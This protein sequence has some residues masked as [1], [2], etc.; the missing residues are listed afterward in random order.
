MAAKKLKRLF[1]FDLNEI[2][3]VDVPAQ[4]PAVP[5]ITKSAQDMQK[6]GRLVT[7]TDVVNGHQHAVRV[8]ENYSG[9]NKVVSVRVMGAVAEGMANQHSHE[10]YRDGSGAWQITTEGGHSH[11]IDSAPINAAIMALDNPNF[12]V[13]DA[14]NKGTQAMT[15]NIELT[16][17]TELGSGKYDHLGNASVRK[18]VLRPIVAMADQKARDGAL[19]AL[20]AGGKASHG[21]PNG[22]LSAWEADLAKSLETPA[23]DTAEAELEKLAEARAD[24]M[25]TSYQQAYNFILKTA[26]GR[27]LGAAMQN[28]NRGSVNLL[29]HLADMVRDGENAKRIAKKAA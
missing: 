25:G 7:A 8:G 1:E 27:D 6:R 26:R 2:S 17:A 5:L 14:T 20:Q 12:R 28:A 18:S 4:E 29:E 11:T 13:P 22:S 21:K 15:A 16:M 10:I 9:A 23:G 19:A 3:A 24:K